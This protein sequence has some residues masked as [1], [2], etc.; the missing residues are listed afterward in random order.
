MKNKVMAGTFLWMFAGLLVTFLTG[1]IVS[2]NENMLY[3]I[4][5]TGA[6]WILILL[7]LGLVIFLSA[8]VLKM[9]KTGARVSFLLYSFVSEVVYFAPP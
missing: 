5:S 9:S 4:F 2:I 3:N 8:K 1:Y 7:E 6:Y